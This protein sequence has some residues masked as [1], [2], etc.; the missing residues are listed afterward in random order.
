MKQVHD[1]CEF[2][3]Q[4]KK[5]VTRSYSYR[6]SQ[7]PFNLTALVEKYLKSKPIDIVFPPPNSMSQKRFNEIHCD[8]LL[9]EKAL[10]GDQLAKSILVDRLSPLITLCIKRLNVRK[11][12]QLYEEPD[13]V[14]E[15][16]TCLFSNGG[17]LL[18]QYDVQRGMSLER[19]IVMVTKREIGNQLR[20]E[21]ANKRGFHVTV[22]FNEEDE[23]I[24]FERETPEQYL[25]AR[26]LAM[27][28]GRTLYRVL[29]ERGIDI[30]RIAFS[31][32]ADPEETAK[33]LNVSVQVVYNW[34]HKIRLL[35]RRL[36]DMESA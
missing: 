30:F 19:Y 31:E 4:Y 12:T 24:P 26:E 27:R 16:W 23:K 22:N 36:V 35:C 2:S 21:Q 15:M 7:H 28:L 1:A 6:S 10:N 25:E 20:K 18:R 13:F 14:Q 8:A 3:A 29:P 32:G 9:I 34:L 17:K 33:Q 11:R 5:G